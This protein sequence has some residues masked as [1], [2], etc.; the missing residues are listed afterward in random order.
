MDEAERVEIAGHVG[1]LGTEL[2]RFAE[3]ARARLNAMQDRGVPN[4]SLEDQPHPAIYLEAGL[5]PWGKDKGDTLHRAE[6]QAELPEPPESPGPGGYFLEAPRRHCRASVQSQER[7]QVFQ[8]LVEI[9]E[10][11][12]SPGELGHGPPR[13]QRAQ[14]PYELPEPPCVVEEPP[15]P[16][17]SPQ[18]AGFGA[19]GR[20]GTPDS[21]RKG[22]G[23]KLF[24]PMPMPCQL[25]DRNEVRA[26]CFMS[27]ALSWLFICLALTLAEAIVSESP[28]DESLQSAA[29][30]LL[31]FWPV[32][33]SKRTVALVKKNVRSSLG[34]N[35]CKVFL[36]HYKGDA[37]PFGAAWYR[38]NVV[39]NLSASG[40][41]FRFMQEAYAQSELQD[42][43]SEFHPAEPWSSSY[44]YVWGLD[45]DVDLTG[46][47]LTRL[48][49]LTRAS[50]ALIV[51]PTFIGSGVNQKHP[52]G[53]LKKGKRKMRQVKRKWGPE[54][55]WT[56]GALRRCRV[57]VASFRR[58][59][60]A[61]RSVEVSPGGA[62]VAADAHMDDPPELGT[63][64]E[65][66]RNDGA[67]SD[68]A[69]SRAARAGI[70]RFERPD[71]RCDYRHTDFVELTAP[72]L[73]MAAL[74]LIFNEC[75]WDGTD[76]GRR[77]VALCW[78]PRR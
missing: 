40:Y 71:P 23:P 42:R 13:A 49:E 77:P 51:G 78:M 73:S 60:P 30:R 68:V 4:L 39:G 26:G 66:E 27:M 74:P 46:T 63:F 9:P 24:L 29:P 20:R 1:R 75:T 11:P 44:D 8:H 53:D 41:K 47:N 64:I 21:G 59:P 48:F 2:I 5:G 58:R 3:L 52:G 10:P 38:R 43:A 62:E 70:W 6:A 12:E 32:D 67:L 56:E 19:D 33:G 25:E 54:L 57:R 7:S 34:R 65:G 17:D 69:S 72:L 55:G 61:Q 18:D 28:Q 16:P 50:K 14:R 76:G 36:A 45:S 22:R 37:A 15:E 31:L 35:C